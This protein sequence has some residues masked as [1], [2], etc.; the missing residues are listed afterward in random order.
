MSD[1]FIVVE[2]K[3]AEGRYAMDRVKGRYTQRGDAIEHFHDYKEID[4]Y[5]DEWNVE[6]EFDGALLRKA[7]AVDRDTE[8]L[9]KRVPVDDSYE[10]R[11][12]E[13]G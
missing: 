6:K 3:Y 9:V 2:R 7:V 11:R 5:P 12:F 4:A 8:I 1:I 13:E 10:V